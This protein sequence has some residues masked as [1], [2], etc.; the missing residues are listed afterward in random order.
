MA[1]YITLV[2]KYDPTQSAKDARATLE[3]M[4]SKTLGALVAELKK[5][6]TSN[7]VSE[8]EKRVTSFVDERNWLAH[9]SWRENSSILFEPAKMPP[10][11][12]RL[13]R[14]AKEAQLLNRLFGELVVTWTL[15]QGISAQE[16]QAETVRRLKAQG[17]L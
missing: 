10:V 8:F 13:K 14:I 17:M 15:S 4:Q 12:E 1:H 5:G 9:D 11:L 16:L 3:K 2:L 6:N 7:S